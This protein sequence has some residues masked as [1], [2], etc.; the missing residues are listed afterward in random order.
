MFKII[1]MSDLHGYLPN[2]NELNY[3]ADLVC[4]CGDIIPLEHQ[5]S[6]ISSF[7][8]VESEFIPW[9]ENMINN[10]ICEKVIFIAGNHDFWLEEVEDKQF[11]AH[12]YW[13]HRNLQ[14]KLIY[15]CNNHYVY[16]DK[17]IFGTPYVNMKSSWAFNVS[18]NKERKTLFNNIPKKTDI[19]LTHEAPSNMGGVDCSTYHFWGD[20]VLEETIKNRNI[21]LCLCGHI[22]D[23]NHTPIEYAEGC[24]IVNVSL[25]ND[26]YEAC[27]EPTIIELDD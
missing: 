2:L 25:L 14:S 21:Q 7:K 4:I 8:W 22:H 16:K 27:Y 9:V 19:L 13:Y 1:A 3:S 5:K 24:K 12:I 11:K 20:P 18:D 15:L 17:I 6:M 10:H 26:H 23:G